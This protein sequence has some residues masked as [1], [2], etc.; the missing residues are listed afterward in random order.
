MLIVFDLDGTLT[1]QRPSSVSPFERRLLGGVADCCKILSTNSH[2]L[3]I[4]SNQGGLK[5]GLSKI[6]LDEHLAWV[7]ARLGIAHIRYAAEPLRKKP[8]PAM[9]LEILHAAG[10]SPG[11]SLFIGDAQSDRAAANAAKVRFI[12]ARQFFAAHWSTSE[13][14]LSH[15]VHRAVETALLP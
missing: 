12:P 14:D 3:A 7:A 2:L 1:P 15:Q 11:A 6:A 4:V 8:S 10:T 9:I 5:R 13:P